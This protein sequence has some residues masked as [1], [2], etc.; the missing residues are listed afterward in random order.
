MERLNNVKGFS[1]S[2]GEKGGDYD[3]AT[4]IKIRTAGGSNHNGQPYSSDLKK[5]RRGETIWIEF[6]MLP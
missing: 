2:C 4:K 1:S 3:T 5:E 6:Y